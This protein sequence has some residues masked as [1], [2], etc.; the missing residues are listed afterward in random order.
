[1]KQDQ[2]DSMVRS[3][4]HFVER[5]DADKIEWVAFVI[6]TAKGRITF[7]SENAPK[8]TRLV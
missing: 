7:A 4:R 8:S 3:F 6:K 2:K 1:M 5:T